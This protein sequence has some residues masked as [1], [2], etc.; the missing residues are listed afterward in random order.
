MTRKL[1]H[2][3]AGAFMAVLLAASLGWG[4]MGDIEN[5]AFQGF[6]GD[7]LGP[8]E[9]AAPDGR[10]DATFSLSLRGV[11]A[12]SG[13]SLKSEN[14][15]SAWDTVAGN[16]V[17]G[18]LVKDGSGNVI[19]G[20]GVCPRPSWTTVLQGRALTPSTCKPSLLKRVHAGVP[21]V[22]HQ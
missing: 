22:Y 6:A 20:S 2:I 8:G 21:S 11:G 16:G 14:G 13:F 7:V 1:R 19:A 9:S 12:V 4:A 3:T 10:P 17:A 18:I 15:K 5:L